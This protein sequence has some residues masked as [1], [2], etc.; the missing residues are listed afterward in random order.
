MPD[1]AADNIGPGLEGI[2]VHILYR[3]ALRDDSFCIDTEWFDRAARQLAVVANSS[4]GGGF[5]GVAHYKI[6]SRGTR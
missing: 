6:S 2:A 4:Y 5:K 1:H 3:I